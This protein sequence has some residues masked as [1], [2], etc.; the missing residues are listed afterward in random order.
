[1]PYYFKLIIAPEI[2]IRPSLAS[3]S[4]DPVLVCKSH[5]GVS[6]QSALSQI[7]DPGRKSLF[8]KWV[9][10][11]HSW[12]LCGGQLPPGVSS[13]LRHDHS[14]GRRWAFLEQIC[15]AQEPGCLA[16]C[17]WLRPGR[18]RGRHRRDAASTTSCALLTRD[19][20]HPR[21]SDHSSTCGPFSSAM[22]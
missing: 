16:G 3:S 18:P 8:Q 15:L 1:L 19:F 10:F 11:R 9:E 12:S 2:R 20:S 13:Q 17:I 6:P 4:K 14:L 22:I 5:L 7:L 21:A